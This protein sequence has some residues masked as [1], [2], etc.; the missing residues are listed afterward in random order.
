VNIIRIDPDG[1]R[2]PVATY[3]N[4][5]LHAGRQMVRAAASDA[6]GPNGTVTERVVPRGDLRVYVAFARDAADA[7]VATFEEEWPTGDAVAARK[8]FEQVQELD[9]CGLV[10]TDDDLLAETIAKKFGVDPPAVY[11]EYGGYDDKE[12]Q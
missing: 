3:E 8:L 5:S 12:D 9:G 11:S 1:R 10:T 7:E 2:A 6:A 4:V